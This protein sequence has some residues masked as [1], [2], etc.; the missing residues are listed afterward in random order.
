[1]RAALIIPVFAITATAAQP[2]SPRPIA[3]TGVTVIDPN[4]GASVP[5]MTVVIREGRIAS[6]GAGVAVPRDATVIDAR[7]QFLMPGLW[8]MHVHLGFARE[9]AFPAFVANGVTA[10]RDL[11]GELA[12]IDRWRTEIATGTRVGPLIVRVGPMFCDSVRCG[13]HVGSARPGSDSLPGHR[14]LRRS[15]PRA[16]A[17]AHRP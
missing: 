6:A 8:D 14:T 15:R 11:G 5:S 10:V 9:S 17:A 3:I 2:P 4:A 1:M 13:R 7:G 12:E 16:R